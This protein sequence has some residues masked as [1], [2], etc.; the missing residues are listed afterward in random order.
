MSK[1]LY[2]ETTGIDAIKTAGEII[3]LLVSVGATQINQQFENRELSGIRWVMK[4]PTG[5]DGLF[6]MPARVEPIYQILQ[7]RRSVKFR[8]KSEQQDREQA[9]R[10]A[11][12]QL[13]RWTQAQVALIET[14][15]VDAAQ[16]WTPYALI[17]GRR[18]WEHILESGNKL[19]E[20]PRG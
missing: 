14:G 7:R 16:P 11:W 18:L 8:G 5:V 15:M 20:A 6:E 2:M 4:L 10:V 12:R 3:A 1:S 19:L 13:L 9:K 17:N